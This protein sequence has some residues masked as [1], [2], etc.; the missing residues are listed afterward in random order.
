[1][2]PANR[3]L[4]EITLI[5]LIK[6]VLD[7][8]ALNNVANA[9]GKISVYHRVQQTWK[10]LLPAGAIIALCGTVIFWCFPGQL[11]Q[12]FSAS[13]EMLTLGI[14]A[15][16]IISVSFV[17]AAITTLCGYFASGLGNGI[18]NMV[19][20]AIRQLILLVPC[21]LIFTKI[22]GISHGWYAVWIA[23]IV[24]C[25]YSYC[26]SHKLQKTI[27]AHQ[28]RIVFPFSQLMKDFSCVITGSL[29]DY[30]QILF[31][32][33]CCPGTDHLFNL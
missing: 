1:M 22:S 33:V 20:A 23:E 21:L 2:I 15:L 17:M 4:I 32:D 5:A 29:T 13:Q 7:C 26:M 18:I 19:S 14:P 24:A 28:L 16:R 12:L 6:S 31:S 10:V 25:I 9:P 8:P 27:F 30:S 11:L 3:K